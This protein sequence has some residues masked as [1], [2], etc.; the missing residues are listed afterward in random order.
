MNIDQYKYTDKSLFKKTDIEKI[1]L[2][3]KNKISD[4]DFF[5][6]GK[7]IP[8]LTRK[9]IFGYKIKWKKV[10][11]VDQWYCSSHEPYKKVYYGLKCGFFIENQGLDHL[12]PWFRFFI[13]RVENSGRGRQ[14]VFLDPLLGGFVDFTFDVFSN[15]NLSDEVEKVD[16]ILNKKNF[17]DYDISNLIYLKDESGEFILS[18]GEPKLIIEKYDYI[19]INE[20][21]IIFHRLNF[22]Y[23]DGNTL[24]GHGKLI[25]NIEEGERVFFEELSSDIKTFIKES[26]LNKKEKFESN[27]VS[28]LEG[29]NLDKQDNLILESES[30]LSKLLKKYQSKII[31]IDRTYIQQFIKVSNYINQKKINLQLI[32]KRL[33]ESKNQNQL[34]ES[35]ET[36]KQEIHSY[37]LILLNSFQMLNSLVEDDMITFYVIYEKFDKLNMFSSNWEN[38]VE[39][40]LD[41]VNLN[42]VKLINELRIVGN[43]IIDSLDNLSYITELSTKQLNSK[44]E[45][46]DSTL[47]V[48]NLINVIQTYQTY[49]L[50]KGK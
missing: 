4:N 17:S 1:L 32:F 3:L 15:P 13:D 24:I 31:E 29:L 16:Y 5:I 38:Q 11:P 42:L 26:V 20:K 37:N 39:E 6:E 10:V 18:G 44:M 19:E 46:I 21:N 48:G 2:K 9:N 35:F 50:R 14:R 33:K 12:F 23:W 45:E 49:K 36:L 43:K 27:K 28:F 8:Q 25:T 47:N 34:E 7:D 22:Q 40:K 41:N 30:E